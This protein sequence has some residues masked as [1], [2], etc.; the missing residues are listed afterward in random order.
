MRG[1]RRR[2]VFVGRVLLDG[3]RGFDEGKNV[4]LGWPIR[5]KIL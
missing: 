3:F 2:S 5:C 4:S 1:L